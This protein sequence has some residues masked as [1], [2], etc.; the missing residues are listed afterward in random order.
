MVLWVWRWKCYNIQVIFITHK[1]LLVLLVPQSSTLPLTSGVGTGRTSLA[2]N[3]ET[4]QQ[5]EIELNQQ[6]TQTPIIWSILVQASGQ[7]HLLS[8][9][10]VT[11]VYIHLG[12]WTQ[13]C[14]Y[15]WWWKLRRGRKILLGFIRKSFEQVVSRGVYQYIY[16][17]PHISFLNWQKHFI[18]QFSNCTN[19]FNNRSL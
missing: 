16:L 11:P 18:F 13:G 17:V 1:T 15:L 6:A 2:Y 19:G 5:I 3:Y 14:G 10:T 12:L 4:P 7:F 9:Q 8:N